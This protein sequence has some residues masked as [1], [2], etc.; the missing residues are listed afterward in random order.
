MDYNLWFNFRRRE[1]GKEET[2]EVKFVE[3]NEM[4]WKMQAIDNM[5]LLVSIRIFW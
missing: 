3:K 4:I 1:G 5:A 2:F